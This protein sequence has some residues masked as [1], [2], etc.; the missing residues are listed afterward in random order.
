MLYLSQVERILRLIGFDIPRDS[1]DLVSRL[2]ADIEQEYLR[3]QS[4]STLEY[5]LHDEEQAR[6]SL[7]PSLCTH[8]TRA[9]IDWRR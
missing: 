1:F 6:P 7:I 3:S 5:L 2:V 8:F 9:G 4:R